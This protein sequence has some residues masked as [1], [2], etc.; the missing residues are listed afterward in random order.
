MYNR[1]AAAPTSFLSDT[2][3]YTTPDAQETQPGYKVDVISYKQ[4]DRTQTLLS[5]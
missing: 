1:N 2:T 4:Y 5:C 3:K